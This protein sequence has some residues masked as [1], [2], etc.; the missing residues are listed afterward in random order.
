MNQTSSSRR[1]KWSY[2]YED[3]Y[4]TWITFF[5]NQS[6]WN[7]IDNPV[8]SDKMILFQYEEK[9]NP[10]RQAKV[11]SNFK[12]PVQNILSSNLIGSAVAEFFYL[13][14]STKEEIIVYI[15]KEKET[16]WI[17]FEFYK[18]N[19]MHIHSKNFAYKGMDLCDDCNINIK[20]SP[21]RKYIFINLN[22]SKYWS[23][24]R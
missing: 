13:S 19:G 4:S 12:S 7:V 1:R 20:V 11:L 17:K 2:S 6:I 21:N 3:I 8:V 5:F 9:S 15:I 10:M 16:G 23:N 14:H 24:L 18:Q 22:S